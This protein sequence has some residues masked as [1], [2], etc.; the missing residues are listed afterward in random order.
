MKISVLIQIHGEEQIKCT[1][2]F[3]LCPLTWLHRF[4]RFRCHQFVENARTTIR[5]LLKSPFNIVQKRS[6]LPLKIQATRSH[7][8][9][10]MTQKQKI[11]R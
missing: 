10:S 8:L 1:F 6:Q 5:F 4:L 7:S 11:E 2:L 3:S 9:N